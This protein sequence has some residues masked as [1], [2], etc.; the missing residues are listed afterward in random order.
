MCR[1]GGLY[2]IAPGTRAANV[3]AN[4]LSPVLRGEGRGGGLCARGGERQRLLRRLRKVRASDSTRRS[5]L[6][7][8]L[9]PEY[10]EEGVRRARRNHHI[11]I[12]SSLRLALTTRWSFR[13]LTFF[14]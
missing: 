7:P 5:P 9:S 3:G 6:S 1:C 12:A 13:G 4:S 11:A 8:T 2:H 14:S 10:R